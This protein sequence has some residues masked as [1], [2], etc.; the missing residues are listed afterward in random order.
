[1]SEWICAAFGVAISAEEDQAGN[2]HAGADLEAKVLLNLAKINPECFV[3]E[4]LIAGELLRAIVNGKSGVLLIRQLEEEKFGV[5]LT[6]Q[7]QE[8]KFGVLLTR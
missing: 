8:E 6:G 2:D 3:Y 7:L 5:L 1:M 4:M